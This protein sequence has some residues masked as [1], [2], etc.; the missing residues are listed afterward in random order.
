[1]EARRFSTSWGS[2]NGHSIRSLY[3]LAELYLQE[4]LKTHHFC[5]EVDFPHKKAMVWLN[6]PNTRFAQ[7][8]KEV[9]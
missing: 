8:I 3:T 2:V 4:K 5:E 1:M 9:I 6:N 7:R